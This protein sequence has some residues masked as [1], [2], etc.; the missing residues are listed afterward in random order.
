MVPNLSR[1]TQSILARRKGGGRVSKANGPLKGLNLFVDD[2]GILRVGGRLRLAALGFRQRHPIV[3]PRHD[4]FVER[5]AWKQHVISGHVGPEQLLAELRRRY[6]IIC[7]RRAVRKVTSSCVTCRRIK[8]APMEQR[9]A[10]LPSYRL[11]VAAPFTDTGVDLLGPLIVKSGRQGMK[12]WVVVFLCMRVR[13]VYLDFVRSIDAESFVEAVQRFHAFYPSVQRLH[14]DQGTNIKGAANLLSNMA[15]E[16]KDCVNKALIPKALEWNFI[17]PHAAW[18]GGGWERM[19]AVVKK[20]LMGLKT[21][22]MHVERFR[23]LLAVAAG[24]INRRPIT[25]VSIDP[26][27]MEPLTPGHFLFPAG[28]PTP[29]LSGDVLPTTPLDGSQMRRRMDGLRPVVDG[30]WKRWLQEY[31]PSLQQRTK[32]LVEKEPLEVGSL[33]LV[34]DDIQPRERWPLA[35]V[36]AAPISGDGL[37]RRVFLRLANGQRLERDIRK[38][39]LLERDGEKDGAVTREV[40]EVAKD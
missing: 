21:Q 39:V 1:G 26:E 3:L 6:W 2:K 20:T 23:T 13:A 15:E 7:G 37:Q 40:V 31:V 32:W 36:T 38:V 11:D 14:S 34:V 9:M 10:D 24:I 18:Y 33:V 28:I 12:V 35:V 22:D 8:A 17:P 4:P 19:V 29:R 5:L 27:D 16:W 25:R 30:L